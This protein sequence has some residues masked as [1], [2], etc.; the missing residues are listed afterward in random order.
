MRRARSYQTAGAEGGRVGGVGSAGLALRG[1]GRPDGATGRGRVLRRCG[2]GGAGGGQAG[3]GEGLPARG[4]GVV[5]CVRTEALA[6]ARVG[7]G[8]G[9]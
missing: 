2:G 4:E 6:V 9:C 1:R 5:R 8:L 7:D 3:T